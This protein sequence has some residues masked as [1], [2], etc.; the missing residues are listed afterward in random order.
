MNNDITG[1]LA[2]MGR[3]KVLEAINDEFGQ[4]VADVTEHGGSGE[5]TVKIKVKGTA[6]DADGRLTEVAVTHSVASKRPKRDLGPSTFFLTRDN[7]LTRNNPEQAE[8]FEQEIRATV[9]E[10]K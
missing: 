2:Q 3:G 4:I 7:V 10:T 1:V 5:L 6:H 9:K 8:L